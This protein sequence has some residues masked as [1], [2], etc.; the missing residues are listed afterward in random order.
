MIRFVP[1]M[2]VRCWTGSPMATDQLST[3]PMTS[4]GEQTTQVFDTIFLGRFSHKRDRFFGANIGQ[5]FS[6]DIQVSGDLEQSQ[7]WA[8]CTGRAAQGG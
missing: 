7:E 1:G 6:D 4:L 8:P 5:H 3:W 2:R